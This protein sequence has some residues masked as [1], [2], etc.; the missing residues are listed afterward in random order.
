MDGLQHAYEVGLDCS[1]SAYRRERQ[2]PVK[3]VLGAAEVDVCGGKILG[4]HAEVRQR[5][6][7]L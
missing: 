3:H 1:T 4:N 7:T 6:V 2:W 5:Q